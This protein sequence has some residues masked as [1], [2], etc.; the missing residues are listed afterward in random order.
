[1]KG[2]LHVFSVIILVVLCACGSKPGEQ[3]E[4]AAATAQAV[5]EPRYAY[6]IK[7]DDY[8]VDTCQVQS[9]ETLSGILNRHGLTAEQRRTVQPFLNKH[10]ELVAIREGGRTVGSGAV[11]EIDE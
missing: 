9:G 1:M 11:T 7:L 3:N 2:Y 6:G 8:Y 4:E 10:P 5:A